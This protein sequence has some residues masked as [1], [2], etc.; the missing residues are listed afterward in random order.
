MKSIVI[1]TNVLVLLIVG[2]TRPTL[3]DSHTAL[4]RYPRESLRWLCDILM[5]YDEHII[6]PGILAETS[7]LLL[8]DKKTSKQTMP[9][10]RAM[11]GDSSFTSSIPYNETNIAIE[12]IVNTHG[13]FWLGVVDASILSLAKSGIPLITSDTKLFLEASSFCKGCINF[14]KFVQ[15]VALKL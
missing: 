2:R 3:I 9:A 13:F 1:D 8:K 10:L 5:N 12:E 6:T 14:N 7:N 15:E 4:S 11:V